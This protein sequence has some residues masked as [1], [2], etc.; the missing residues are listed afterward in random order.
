MRLPRRPGCRQFVDVVGWRD[1]YRSSR[2]MRDMTAT[3]ILQ[4]LAAAAATLATALIA[5]SGV[6]LAATPLNAT[7]LTKYVDP[8]PIPGVAEQAAP[9]YYELHMQQATVK[10]HR[11]LPPTTVWG[12]NGGYLGPTFVVRSGEGIHVRWFNDLPTT[13]LLQS[14]IDYTLDS[15]TLTDVRAVTHLHGGHVADTSDGGPDAWFLPGQSVV[16]EYPNDQ[17]ATLLWYHDHAMGITRLNPY[18]GLAGAYI[19]RDAYEDSLNLPGGPNDPAGP[20]GPYEVPLVIQDKTFDTDGNLT[21]PTEGV[22]PFHPQWVPEFFGDTIVVNGKIWPYLQVEPRKYRFRIINGSNARFYE[23]SLATAPSRAKFKSTIYQIGAE[24]GLL[25]T[26]APTQQL[27]IAPGER[28]DIIVDFRASAGTT[29]LLKNTARAPYPAGDADDPQT[30]GQVMQ[31]RVASTLSRPDT[32]TIPANPRLIR[33]LVPTPGAPV[34]DVELSEEIDPFSDEP[35]TLKLEDKGYRDPVTLNP[36]VGT[37]EI[38]RLIN[39]TGDTHPIHLHLVQFQV[40]DRQSF[41]VSEYLANGTL[42]LRGQPKPPNANELGWKDTVQVDPG[43]VVSIIARFDRVG[44]YPIHCHIL[45]HEENEMMRPFQV[46]P[47]P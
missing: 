21:Y 46:L 4:V 33:R 15:T 27:L 25:P 36:K 20:Y 44:T 12:Y 17:E 16:Y 2:E 28:A 32:T 5:G 18:L 3:R 10:M 13:H 26:V 39:T 30:V 19:I 1:N 41:K 43:D 7:T 47:A 23:L 6:A 45:E 11:D 22:T 42:K 35:V 8:L 38:W 24:G 37:T 14:S 9:G 34:R 31:F 40:L 29:V